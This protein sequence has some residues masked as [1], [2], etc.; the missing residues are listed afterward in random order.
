MYR[1]ICSV[2]FSL[3][4]MANVAPAAVPVGSRTDT[5]DVKSIW[6]REHVYWHYVESN[7][8]K[9]Y[10]DLWDKDF[11]GWPSVS[12]AP[13]HK[14]HI[15]DW[16]TSQT[17]KGLALKVVEFKP[18]A[19]QVTGDVATT[20]YWITYRWQD[21][22]GNGEAHTLRITHTWVRRKNTWRIIS[23][24]SMPEPATSPKSS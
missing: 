7:D 18:A 5:Q 11:L 15:T 19:I 1:F 8:L 22:D 6:S 14:D 20:C 23:G 3:L 12:P 24:M 4:M 21:K 9:A 16:I 10:S 17:G 2:T 13:V